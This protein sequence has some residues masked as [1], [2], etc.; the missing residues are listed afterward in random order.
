MKRNMSDVCT[1]AEICQAIAA[2]FK[3]RGLTHETAAEKLETTKQTVSN[4]I[5]GKKKFSVKTAQKY[6]EA[7]GYSLEFLLFGKGNLYAPGRGVAITRPGQLPELYMDTSVMNEGRKVRTAVRIL[8]ILNNQTAIAAYQAALEDDAERYNELYDR[9]VKEFA[10]DIPFVNGNKEALM[11]IRKFF[12]DAHEK[13]AKEL[14][15]AERDVWEGK[16]V[17]IEVMLERY[18]RELITLKDMYPENVVGEV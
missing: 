4:Q 5:S 13:A 16:V 18:R 8:E 11:K 3:M 7:F 1:A 6:S 9:L 10:W 2:D 14:I 12:A 15:Q 17:D